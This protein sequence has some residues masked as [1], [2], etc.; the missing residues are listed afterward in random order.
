MGV[1]AFRDPPDRLVWTLRDILDGR[2]PILEVAH[3]EDGEADEWQ[4]LTGESFYTDEMA[5]VPL[6][7]I[8]ELDP[9]VSAVADL[10][11]ETVF[12]REVGG[13]WLIPDEPD[14]VDGCTHPSL[15]ILREVERLNREAGSQ[16]PGSNAEPGAA[17]DGGA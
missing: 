13:E 5:Q 4:F 11:D 15:N 1:W 17:A 14:E 9:S 3:I 16:R 12:R 2:K 8:V 6:S 10:Y 7:R